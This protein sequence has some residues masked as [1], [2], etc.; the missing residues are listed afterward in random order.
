MIQEYRNFIGGEWAAP[1]TGDWAEVRNPAD[2]DDVLG[3]VPASG[4][5]DVQAAIAAARAAFPAWAGLTA[6]ER[7]RVLHR[8]ANLL[9]TQ[10]D[11]WAAA[12]SREEGKTRLEAQREVVRS[13]E[14]LRYFA[15]E[16][17]RVGGDLLPAD[18]PLTL[19][20]SARVPLGVCAIITP[21]NFPLSIPVWKI[22]PALV[23]GN[24]VVFKP[25]SATP[26]MA[27]MLARLL[28]EA[29]LPAGVLNLVAG[30]GGALGD[31]LVTDPGI[32]AVSFTGSYSVGHALYQKTAPRMTRTH[33][34]MGGKNPVIVAADADIQKAVQIV[35]AGAFGLT[36]QACTAT[37]RVIV[38]Q[39]IA[40]EFA[41]R[42]SAAA[43]AWKVGPGLTDGVQM[44]PAVSKGQRQTDLEYIEVARGEGAT[45]LAGGSAPAD[46]SYARGY[47]VQPT[48]LGNVKP[49][50]RIAQEEVFGPVVGLI[51]AADLDE[52]FAIANH[53]T[54]G[55]TAGIVTTDLR[56]ALRFAERAEA[57]MIK[58]NQGTVG[59]SIQAPF[60]GF[61]NSGSGMFREMG[62]GA[63]EF[64]T[65]IKTV[66]I[67]G[68]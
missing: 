6:P 60:G 9:E 31:A 22:A 48:V 10:A 63:V 40:R 30:A 27:I 4:L 38:E 28:H 37:S 17:W 24:T 12:L 66:Y 32:D 62:K 15:G 68:Q 25:A 43:L 19:L 18:T 21:W 56:R 59:A 61:K 51:E 55:L 35:S 26:I 7:G 47:F 29:G 8:A 52:A 44:G 16:A 57:G 33:L 65:K 49:D 46:G 39:P 67:D 34:E 5:A 11:T 64:F 50:M 14:L 45:V 41:E 36:G 23:V 1:T 20:Y 54:Y 2:T 42:L 3:S 58:V 13:V 53:T